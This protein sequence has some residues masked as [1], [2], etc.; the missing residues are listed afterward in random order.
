V[1]PNT[2]AFR[3]ISNMISHAITQAERLKAT[4]EESFK[5]SAGAKKF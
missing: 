2:T 3:E 4:M 5:T 1:Q